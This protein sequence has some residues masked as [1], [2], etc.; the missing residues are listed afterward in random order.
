M[1]EFHRHHDVG[2]HKKITCDECGQATPRSVT[3]DGKKL[4]FVCYQADRRQKLLDS[5]TAQPKN[6]GHYRGQI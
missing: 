5:V 3:V 4:C 2:D 1:S 6:R